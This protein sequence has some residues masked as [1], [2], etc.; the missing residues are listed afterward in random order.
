MIID[1]TKYRSNISQNH[2]RFCLKTCIF[3]LLGIVGIF[4]SPVRSLA[5]YPPA[6]VWSRGM[7]F[8]PWSL[9]ECLDRGRRALQA[10]GYTIDWNAGDAH[11]GY[12]G[13]HSAFIMCDDG[14][15]GKLVV[16]I[17][18]SS[19][20]SD[21]NLPE[22]ERQKLG[23]QMGK[24]AGT[25]CGLGAEWSESEGG[26][27]GRWV[28]R[29]DSNVFDASWG[30]I[31][32]VLTMTL[33]GNSVRIARRQSSDGNDCDYTGTIQADG[34]TVQG[35]YTCKVGAK[36]T[37]WRATIR[38]GGSNSGGPFT[39][40]WNNADWVDITLQQTS[41]Q[42]AG[43]YSYSRGGSIT[44]VVTGNSLR[45]TWVRS[46][47]A[48]GGEGVM[49]LRPDGNLDIIYCTGLGC[50]PSGNPSRATKK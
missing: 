4:I 29:G 20:S 12:K 22:I 9:R 33:S 42:V 8:E 50:T 3:M 5:Q 15:Q 46:G 27:T 30:K 34:V 41:N 2:I 25:G 19:N 31:T 36:D 24:P 23:A 6:P 1:D 14:P 13:I 37:A 40:T 18:V 10:E 43:S 7:S 49:T 35:V 45:F 39:G 48:G 44:G 21:R 38:C 17:V 28:R 32:A 47:N 26:F 11:H 16:N